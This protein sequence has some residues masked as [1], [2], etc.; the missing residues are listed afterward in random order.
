[1]S[2]LELCKRNPAADA[3]VV[4]EILALLPLWAL[5]PSQLARPAPAAC[6]LATSHLHVLLAGQVESTVHRAP[7]EQ[8]RLRHQDRLFG[9]ETT[10]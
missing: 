9:V 4:P 1:M 10:K 3:L 5:F 2:F 8:R 6:A 7:A